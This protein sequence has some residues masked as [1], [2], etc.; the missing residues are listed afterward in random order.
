MDWE[1]VK[2]VPQ[3]V[4]RWQLEY[5]QADP[6]EEEVYIDKE[7]IDKWTDLISWKHYL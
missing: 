5:A 1:P 4:A 2:D 7:W 3:A 6:E